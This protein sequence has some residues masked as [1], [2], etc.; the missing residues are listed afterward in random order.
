VRTSTSVAAS[1]SIPTASRAAK[2]EPA[3]ASSRGRWPTSRPP[4]RYTIRAARGT[5][6][7][8]PATRGQP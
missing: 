4:H 6:Q 2:I 5:R 1:V 8:P 7:P 3:G